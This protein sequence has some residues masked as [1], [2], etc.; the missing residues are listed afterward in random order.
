VTVVA[1]VRAAFER[2]DEFGHAGIL[3]APAETGQLQ[4]P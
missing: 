4:S 1:Q 2:L 3:P